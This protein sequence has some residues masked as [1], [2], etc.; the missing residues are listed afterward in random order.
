M[1]KKSLILGLA[2]ISQC[3]FASPGLRSPADVKTKIE[4]G[5]CSISITGRVDQYML[6]EFQKQN[7]L[8]RN[9]PCLEKQVILNSL[10]GVVEVAYQIGNIVRSAGYNTLVKVNDQCNSACTLIF[11]AGLERTVED[12]GNSRY[13]KIGFHAYRAEDGTCIKKKSDS[14]LVEDN[15]VQRQLRA[16]NYAASMLGRE[17]GIKFG[18]ITFAIDCHDMGFAKPEILAKF[19]F[20]TKVKQ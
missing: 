1:I 2:L 6:A 9:W 16:Y 7:D 20:A 4:D 17:N 13:S 8:L 19:N 10:G 5:I 14:N 12:L 3:V 15:F 18:Q 11:I